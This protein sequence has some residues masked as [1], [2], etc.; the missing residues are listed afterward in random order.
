MRCFYR[1]DKTYSGSNY[2]AEEEEKS[3][4]LAS[5]GNNQEYDWYFDSG[6]RNHVTHQTEKFQE[7]NEHHGKNSLIIVNGEQLEIIATGSSK[8][9]SLNLHD[10]LYVPNITKNLLS[11]SKLAA[12]NNILVEFDKNWCFVKDKLT[13]KEVL[14]GILKDGLYQLSGIERSPSAYIFV[15]ESWHKTTH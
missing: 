12:D 9:K 13:G 15:R 7:I 14:K 6:A 2:L 11:V 4:F 1:F 3:T 5:Q 8:L 10:I